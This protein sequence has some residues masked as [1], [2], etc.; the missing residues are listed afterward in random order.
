VELATDPI[1]RAEL[2]EYAVH[3]PN[4]EVM[5]WYGPYLRQRVRRFLLVV[6]RWATTRVRWLPR[7]MVHMIILRV[8]AVEYV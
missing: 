3:S 1:I 5:R 6:Q 8:M 4:R 7:D 2:R